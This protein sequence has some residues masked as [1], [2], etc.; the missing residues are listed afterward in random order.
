MGP[1]ILFTHLKI[2][3][4]QC[5]QFSATISS[6]QTYPLSGKLLVF[7]RVFLFTLDI[8]NK[9]IRTLSSNFL[10]EGWLITN[11]ISRKYNANVELNHDHKPQY[12][13][14]SFWVIIHQAWLDFVQPKMTNYDRTFMIFYLYIII[15]HQAGI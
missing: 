7:E 15:R 2:I 10:A 13:H 12:Q 11:G 14:Q 3:L 4:L 6:I 1:T 8:I 5:F 9:K